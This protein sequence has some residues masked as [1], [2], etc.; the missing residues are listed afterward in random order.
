MPDAAVLRFLAGLGADSAAMARL[1]HAPMETVMAEARARGFTF[2]ESTFADTLWQ[3][4]MS[5]AARIGE[6]FD[7]NCSLWETMWGRSYLD[8]LALTVAPVALATFHD[9]G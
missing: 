4:E 7:F 2:D 6:P 3:T 5:L 8:Y 1:R 9:A